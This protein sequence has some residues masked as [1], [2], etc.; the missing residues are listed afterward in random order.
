MTDLDTAL[1]AGRMLAAQKAH[2]H[3]RNVYF[4]ACALE[5]PRW[6]LTSI[7]EDGE[8]RVHADFPDELEAE[9]RDVV[10]KYLRAEASHLDE[11]PPTEHGEVGA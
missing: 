2:E 1:L 7:D 5:R 8:H 4:L 11:L 6:I 3:A 9:L 10:L